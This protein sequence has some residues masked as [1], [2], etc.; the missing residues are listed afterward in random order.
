M[1]LLIITAISEFEEEIIQQL[2][3]AKV[4]SFSYKKVTRY[5]DSSV[6]LIESN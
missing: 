1:K 6:E 5:R 3:K 2:K 4:S